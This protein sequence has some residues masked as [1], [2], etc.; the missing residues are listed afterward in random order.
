MSEDHWSV[1]C[2]AIGQTENR[3]FPERQTQSSNHRR[4]KDIW[5]TQTDIAK[6]YGLS[7]IALGKKLKELGYRNPDGTP[8]KMAIKG[9][10]VNIV[11]SNDG[12][13]YY[14]WHRDKMRNVLAQETSLSRLS[15]LDY[16]VS[17]FNKEIEKINRN[18]SR[19][20]PYDIVLEKF[21]PYIV[22]ELVKDLSKKLS[23]EDKVKFKTAINYESDDFYSIG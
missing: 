10:F 2:K 1:Y 9:E 5:S 3:I 22:D 14:M 12:I 4:F 13:D 11:T 8:T 23:K 16:A 15:P 6:K 20:D 18:A 17:E 21:G 7:S 19:E